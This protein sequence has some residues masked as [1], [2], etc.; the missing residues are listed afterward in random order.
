MAPAI[1]DPPQGHAVE[2]WADFLGL[3]ASPLFGPRDAPPAGHHFALLDGRRGSF[4]LSFLDSRVVSPEESRNWRWSSDLAH[5]VEVTGGEVFVRTGR[6]EQRRFSRVSVERQLDAFFR[7]LDAPRHATLPDVVEFLLEE[8]L[9]VWATIPR[10]EPNGGHTAL[11]AFL[12]GLSAADEADASLLREADW[13]HRRALELGLDESTA[14]LMD[15]LLPGTLIRA[16]TLQ[17]RAPLG[18]RLAPSLVLRHAAGRLFQD[19]HAHLESSGQLGLFGDESVSLIPASSPT[20]A[21][22]TPV[23]I[24]RLLAESALNR[25]PVLP[26]DLTIADYACGSGV[27]LTEALRVL[28]RRRYRG[29]VRLV[30]RDISAEAVTMARV[31]I[32]TTVRDLIGMQVQSDVLRADALDGGPWP[33]ADVI[34]MNPPFR[35]WERMTAVEKDW[36]RSVLPERRSGRADLSVGFIARALDALNSG[37]VL[38]TLLPAGV[39]ASE[40]LAAWRTSLLER[41]RPTLV[42][43]LGEHGLFR[44]ALVNVGV[45]ALVKDADAPKDRDLL[46][47]AWAAADTGAAAGAMRAIRRVAREFDARPS[48]MAERALWTV[49]RTTLMTLEERPS[50][51]PGANALGPLLDAIRASIPTRVEDLFSVHQGIRTGANDVFVHSRQVVDTLPERERVWFVPAIVTESFAAGELQPGPMV[52]MGSANWETEDDVVAAIPQFYRQV[53]EPARE[54]LRGRAGIVPE[55]WWL[56]TRPRGWVRSG[57]PRLVSKRFGLLPAFARDLEGRSAVLQANAWVPKSSLGSGMLRQSDRIDVLRGVLTAYWWMLNSTVVVALLREY[58][59]NVA[60]GQLDLE[61]KYVRH[62]PM[63]NL[64]GA[65]RDDP[66]LDA[67]TVDIRK[68]FAA[69]LPPIELRDQFAAAAFKTHL[70]DWSGFIQSGSDL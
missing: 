47:L 25:W 3:A 28:E 53:L 14:S 38:A 51:L 57:I 48:R 43:V 17:G 27:F 55:K 41:A 69:T 31:A 70:G 54:R 49:T 15:E 46:T 68:R 66:G 60:G 11:T 26:T 45:L 13:R 18:L 30:G 64:I 23:P 62:V 7:F 32:A 42:A 44:H 65:L 39:L 1:V 8:F 22:F 24:A 56:L 40:G 12:V 67:L 2:G 63:P 6:D 35:S 34:L 5:H 37:G 29:R 16:S 4:A 36:V 20:G 52:F 33:T 10:H 58:C 21:Y 59:P 61:N 19:A 9:Q 50:W